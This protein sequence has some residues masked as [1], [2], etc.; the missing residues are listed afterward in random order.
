MAAPFLHNSTTN[1]VD[2]LHPNRAG[3]LKMGGAVD[4]TVLAPASQKRSDR[5]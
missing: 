1:A 2:H 4:I 3:Y 5:D